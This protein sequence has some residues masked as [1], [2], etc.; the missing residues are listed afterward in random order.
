M[1]WHE[2]LNRPAHPAVLAA[3]R[4]ALA[5]SDEVLFVAESTRQLYA[6]LVPTAAAALVPYGLDIAATDALLAASPR[7]RTRADLGIPLDRR[8]LLCVG[9]VEPRKGQLALARAFRR[10]GAVADHASLYIVGATDT[11]YAQAVRDYVRDAGLEHVHVIDSDPDVMRW[12]AAADVLVSAADV[13]SM[14]RTMLE[15]MLAGRPV[16]A[17]SVFGVPELVEDGVSGWLCEPGDLAALTELVRQAATVGASQL[18][19]MG[20]AARARVEEHHSS[21]GFVEHVAARLQGWLENRAT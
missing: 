21:A 10:L 15:A 2:Y 7:D 3:T 8:V 20:T 11:A 1:F 17:V 4:E 16:A 12:Y 9:S 6:D 18:S 14:P 13:E 5:S 19:L